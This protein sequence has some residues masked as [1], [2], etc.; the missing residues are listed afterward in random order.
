MLCESREEAIAA[1]RA[2]ATDRAIALLAHLEAVELAPE[3]PPPSAPADAVFARPPA[4]AESAV[5]AAA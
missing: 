2:A 3:A 4:I 1:S 5:R